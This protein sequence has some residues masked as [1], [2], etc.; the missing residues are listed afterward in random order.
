MARV[1][2]P[3]GGRKAYYGKTRQEMAQKLVQAQKAL[4]DGLPLAGERQATGAFL[5]AWL[6]DTHPN[7]MKP[8][9][10]GAMLFE[11]VVDFAPFEG[12]GNPSQYLLPNRSKAE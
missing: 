10:V 4:A 2:L 11:C 12:E 6:R 7:D 8:E 3:G 9:D 5:E 1:S